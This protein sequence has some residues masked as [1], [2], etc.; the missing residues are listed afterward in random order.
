MTTGLSSLRKKKA[1]VAALQETNPVCCTE[2]SRNTMLG[3]PRL[4]MCLWGP[5]LA[6]LRL[7][8]TRGVLIPTDP[9]LVTGLGAAFPR[10]EPPDRPAAQ[11]RPQQTPPQPRPAHGLL[12]AVSRPFPKR[13]CCCLHRVASAPAV[14]PSCLETR[15]R[16][17]R[18]HK[19]LHMAPRPLGLQRRGPATPVR[20][21]P[22][23]AP[24]LF[25]AL[26]DESSGRTHKL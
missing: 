11:A 26:T 23:L 16:V 6:S 19:D 18:H 5:E 9:V 17:Q 8:R 12:G 13:G 20:I 2:D 7:R 22:F 25:P 1:S 10:S 3:E 4:S 14:V 15:R 21:R 24:G